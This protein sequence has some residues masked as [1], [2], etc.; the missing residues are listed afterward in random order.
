MEE[1]FCDDQIQ[2]LT[3]KQKQERLLL[4]LEEILRNEK[5]M[6]SE[7][8]SRDFIRSSSVDIL[9]ESEE[10]ASE[11]VSNHFGVP[12]CVQY[13]LYYLW[14]GLAVLGSSWLGTN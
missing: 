11:C 5:S 12:L 6:M 2:K 9:L 10:T 14:L 7:L 13:S 3:E 4:L 8:P 1:L